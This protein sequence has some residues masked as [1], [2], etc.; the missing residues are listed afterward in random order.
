[1]ICVHGPLERHAL[2]G[3]FLER[4][5][6]GVDGFKQALGAR[7][8]YRLTDDSEE[9]P[10]SDQ[11]PPSVGVGLDNTGGSQETPDTNRQAGARVAAP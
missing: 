4:L 8:V 7:R 9:R 2:S 6:V 3:H 1:L 10:A 11:K 5:A